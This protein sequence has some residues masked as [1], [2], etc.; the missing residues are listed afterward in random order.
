MKKPLKPTMGDGP[1]RARVWIEPD[2][3]RRFLEQRGPEHF[4][5]ARAPA[6]DA[7]YPVVED[8]TGEDSRGRV[9]TA[10]FACAADRRYATALLRK[11]HFRW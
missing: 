8:R 4:L 2:E 1:R 6:G 3:R 5:G 10:N 11:R 7:L 9:R